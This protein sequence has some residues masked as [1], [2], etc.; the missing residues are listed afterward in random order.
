MLLDV[1]CATF[2]DARGYCSTQDARRL[3]QNTK[4]ALPLSQI[5]DSDFS[6]VWSDASMPWILDGHFHHDRALVV[7]PSGSFS[8]Y[9]LSGQDRRPVLTASFG[10]PLD[11]VLFD[12][13]AVLIGSAEHSVAYRFD[14]LFAGVIKPRRVEAGESTSCFTPFGQQAKVVLDGKARAAVPDT[15]LEISAS[16]SGEYLA[17][18][19]PGLV[20]LLMIKVFLISVGIVAT[21]CSSMPISSRR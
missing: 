11:T 8:V 5:L 12:D 4:S 15:V 2:I 7:A 9:E 3:L 19:S 17:V 21:G 14:D 6:R 18:V 13:D 10:R 16:P 1:A 20:T